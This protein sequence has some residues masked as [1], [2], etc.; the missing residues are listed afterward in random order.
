LKNSTSFLGYEII[1]L[2]SFQSNTKLD[3]SKMPTPRPF[4]LQVPDDSLALLKTKLSTVRLPVTNPEGWTEQQGVSMSS[5]EHLLPYWL[6]SYLPRWR[7]REGEIN[8]F[9]MYTIPIDAGEF[10][11]LNIH[12]VW[13]K[14]NRA[15]SVPL[16]FIHG[17]PGLFLEGKK[18]WDKLAEGERDGVAFDVIVPSLPN[19][20]FSDGVNT[21][22]NYRNF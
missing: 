2:N 16:L 22:R 4:K 19:F 13:K 3:I 5:M 8:K 6:N 11:T 1:Q 20:G 10:G 17:W 14:A 21:V 7:E 18:I 12:F 9:P 15:N